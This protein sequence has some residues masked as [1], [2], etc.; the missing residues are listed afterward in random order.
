VVKGF[1]SPWVE[2]MPPNT[3]RGPAVAGGWVRLGGRR[4]V[5]ANCR[6]E[7]AASLGVYG[8]APVNKC[9]P[10]VRSTLGC[11]RPAPA[12]PSRPCSRRCSAWSAPAG[13]APWIVL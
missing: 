6:D 10:Y 5:E 12:T 3:N 11:W 1:D 2:V 9:S 7:V 4:P 8:M 13:R